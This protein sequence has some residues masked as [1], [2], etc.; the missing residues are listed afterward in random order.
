MN[1][2][3]LRETGS[4]SPGPPVECQEEEEEEDCAAGA[5]EDDRA[6]ENNQK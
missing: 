3:L 1:V 2:C 5:E 6:R 4:L